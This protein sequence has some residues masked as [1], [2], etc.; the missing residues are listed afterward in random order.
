MKSMLLMLAAAGS[1]VMAELTGVD[2]EHLTGTGV[3][4]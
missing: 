1:L 2:G 4:A 3:A